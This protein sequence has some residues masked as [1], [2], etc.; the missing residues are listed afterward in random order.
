MHSAGSQVRYP[1]LVTFPNAEIQKRVNALLADRE[2]ERQRNRIQ[3]LNTLRDAKR[4]IGKQAFT[5]A[6]TVS[7]LSPRY[8]SLDIRQSDYC[9]GPYP[10]VDVPDPLT[11]DLTKAAPLDWKAVFKP[12]SLPEAQGNPDVVQPLLALYRAHYA[13][14][15]NRNPACQNAVAT[16][17][18]GFTWRLDASRGLIA[19]PDFPHALQVCAVELALSP[20]EI[21]PSVAD[22]SFLAD[23]Q[24]TLKSKASSSTGKKQ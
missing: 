6:V 21:A 20:Q 3:C 16:S 13:K 17:V 23:L 7:Y 15:G 11:L 2:A 10:D 19:R 18:F 8:L 22:R 5:V 4:K 1:R 9:G 24:A 12:G 14:D